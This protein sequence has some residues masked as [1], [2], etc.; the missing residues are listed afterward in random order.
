[1]RALRIPGEPIDFK[2]LPTTGDLIFTPGTTPIVNNA[3]SLFGEYAANMIWVGVAGDVHLIGINGGSP[4]VFKNVIAGRWH[5]I[6]PFIHV[7][8]GSTATNIVIGITAG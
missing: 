4:V 6:G 3:N 8:N 7:T 2:P 5:K 1:M